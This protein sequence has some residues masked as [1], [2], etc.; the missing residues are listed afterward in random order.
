MHRT[1]EGTNAPVRVNWFSDRIEVQNPGGLYGQVT[2][3]NYEQ[4]TDYRNPVIAEA[5]K[6]LGYVDRFGAGIARI[7][8]ALSANGNPPA[9]FAFQPTHVSVT[10]RSR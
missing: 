6:V 7:Q 4:V 10:I 5:L 9:D 3:Q 8:S 1:Y 2:T